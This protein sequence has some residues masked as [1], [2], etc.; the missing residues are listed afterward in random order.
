MEE[1]RAGKTK[2]AMMRTG[3]TT[4]NDGWSDHFIRVKTRFRAKISKV[5]V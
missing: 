5:L 3:E 2:E 4:S 1:V